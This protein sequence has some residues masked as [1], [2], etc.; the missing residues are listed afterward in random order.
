MS[1]EE[2]KAVVRRFWEQCVNRQD[3]AAVDTLVAPEFVHHGAADVAQARGP[4]GV[5]RWAA[6]L[7]A[8][9]PDLQVTIDDVIAEGDKVVVR[10]TRTGTHRGPLLGLP[11]TGRRATWTA[12]DIFRIAGGKIMERWDE[13]DTLGLREQLAA[14]PAAADAPVGRSEHEVIGT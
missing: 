14:G 9:L 2:S 8:A 7:R 12:I 1:T 6:R 4:E 13:F 11:P 5:R 3:L 10:S